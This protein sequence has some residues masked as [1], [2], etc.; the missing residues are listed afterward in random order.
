MLD[1]KII[2]IIMKKFL[3]ALLMTV[4]CVGV[5]SAADE[6]VRDANV[7]PKAARIELKKNF[8]AGINLI[9]LDKTLGR[10]TDY[11]VILTDGTEVSYD[12][13]GNWEEVEVG[14]GKSV[15]AVYIPA[16]VQKYVR[17]NHKG[18]AIVGIDKGRSSY[19][20]KLSDGLE[21]KFDAQGNFKKYDD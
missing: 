6:Y 20:V 13:D 5:A 12:S 9:K 8:K 18:A 2:K 4:V 3:I 15:P 19:E 11:E 17:A 10:V 7:L 21:L 1:I 16:G 14:R